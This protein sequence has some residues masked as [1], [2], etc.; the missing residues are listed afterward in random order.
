[1]KVSRREFLSVMTAMC[2]TG[3]A[4]SE[5][6]F[7]PLKTLGPV[8]TY[9]RNI[10]RA[11]KLMATSTP[12]K[13][14]TVKVL[15]Y[16]QSITEQCWWR[17]VADYLQRQFP[18]ANLVIE[19]RA[20][21]GHAAQ[22]LVKTAEADL[23][24]FYPDL[25]IFHVYGSHIEYEN[26]IRRVRERTTADILMQ[27]DH[28]TSEEQ[29]DEKTDPSKLYPDAK[30]WNA[31]MNHKFLP[32]TARK[33]GCELA[34]VHNLWKQ[35][36]RDYNLKPSQLLRD[37]VHLNEWGCYLMAEIIKSYLRYD[38][39]FREDEWRD[40]VKTYE[41]G[42]DVRWRNGKLVLE[43]EG[44]RVDAICRKGSPK[45]AKVLIDGRPP[46]NHPELYSFTRT[47]AY[48]GS[49]WPCLLKVQSKAPLVIE[50]WTLTITEL[51]SDGKFCQFRV[52]GS[53]TGF[54]GEG[55]SDQ[56]FVS[57]SGRIVIEPDDWNIAYAWKV[58]GK[59]VDVGFQIRWKVVPQFV[60]TFVPPE[61]TDPTIETTVTLAQ[62]LKGRRHVLEIH[63]DEDV[64]IE[65]LR[66]YCPPLLSD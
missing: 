24:P 5:Q 64:P 2:L 1:V 33:Y 48:P 61:I 50:E 14:N 27:T 53:V 22:L 8:E 38:P 51:S 66:V 56:R 37:G 43:F 23:Y 60:D 44:N 57:Q 30:I 11:M 26:I 58:F 40:H 15:F 10:Q 42:K 35:Y 16:G 36:L 21:G 62:G 25:L 41:V 39:S 63:G 46:S 6:R 29:L 18:H 7:P 19:N 3:K 49:N 32:E 55:R 9:G 65:A 20:I 13:R 17:Q 52:N 12:Q 31:F 45:P 47:T 54:D 34:D 4:V 28:I 59:R